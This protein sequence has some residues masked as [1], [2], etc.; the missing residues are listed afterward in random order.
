MDN[1]A[2]QTSQDVEALLT[3]TS[4]NMLG[5]M[6]PGL[7]QD[8]LYPIFLDVLNKTLSVTTN[9]ELMTLNG[10]QIALRILSGMSAMVENLPSNMSSI[11]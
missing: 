4:K 5:I 1:P 7:P 9:Y 2:E 6:S 8:K 3:I 11:L 10:V